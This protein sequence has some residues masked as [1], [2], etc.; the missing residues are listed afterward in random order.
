M[1]AK[2]G[3]LG[4]SATKAQVSRIIAGLAALTLTACATP[5]P[6]IVTK[7]V[8]VAIP[9]RCTPDPAPQKPTLPDYHSAPD[10]FEG[11]KALIASDKL[12]TAY[13]GE[14]EAALSGCE[15]E[16]AP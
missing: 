10:I 13:E 7:T 15:G 14:L 3:Q 12:H 1:S 6:R 4:R 9:V 11:V 5:E 2:I 8:N 16:A